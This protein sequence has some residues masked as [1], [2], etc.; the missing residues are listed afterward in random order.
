MGWWV[1]RRMVV[2][3][4]D[5]HDP[6]PWGCTRPAHL[7]VED[8]WDVHI[9]GRGPTGS[10]TREGATWWT[11]PSKAGRIARIAKLRPELL[12][13]EWSSY[14]FLA[15]P[16]ARFTWE[17]NPALARSGLKRPVQRAL[18][19]TTSAVSYTNPAHKAQWPDQGDREVDLAYPVELSRWE[20]PVPRDDAIW[21]KVG[22]PAPEGPLLVCVANLLRRKRQ[23]EVMH[24]LAPLLQAR[25]D[26]RLDFVGSPDLEPDVAEE[27]RRTI[28]EWGLEAQVHL[29]GW[30]PREDARRVYAWATAMVFNSEL[31]TQCMS[32][33]EALASGVPVLIPAQPEMVT[34][35]PALPSHDGPA[36]LQRN[37]REILDHPERGPELVAACHDRL[38]W[39][40]VGRHDDLVRTTVARLTHRPTQMAAAGPGG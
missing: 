39:A 30:L 19:R 18:L 25:P 34:A 13:N 36:S 7:L 17:R 4:E 5:A 38:R 20:E 26:V 27:I 1:K 15:R 2:L 32:V 37:V 6:L 29:L 16:F 14:G 31:E 40:D 23:V 8:G 9:V 22:V 10:T 35:F 11:E 12:L 33:Y 21:E 24:W 3:V 28:A